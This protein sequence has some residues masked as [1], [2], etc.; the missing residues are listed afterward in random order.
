MTTTYNKLV[1]DKIPEIILEQG[2]SCEYYVANSNEISRRLFD[3]IREEISE[4][5]VDA[6]IE[7]AADIFEVFL[8]M[9]EHSNYSLSDVARVANLKAAKRGRFQKCIV[10]TS[11]EDDL[12]DPT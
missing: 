3:K 2:K 11:V 12:I 8:R 1:R 4:F 7:E 10:L 6:T 5:E 9:L